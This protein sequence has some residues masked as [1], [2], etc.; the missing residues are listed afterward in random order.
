VRL[1]FW[2]PTTRGGIGQLRRCNGRLL[3][4]REK[5]REREGGKVSGGLRLAGRGEPPRKKKMI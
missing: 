1:W 2:E 4:G 5:A 3:W